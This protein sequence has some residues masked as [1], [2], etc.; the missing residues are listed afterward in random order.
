MVYWTFLTYCEPT[1]TSP[2]HIPFFC[3]SVSN[4]KVH[5]VSFCLDILM[6]MD[7]QKIKHVKYTNEHFKMK[8][9]TERMKP[10]MD[11]FVN[12]ELA[13]KWWQDE[14]VQPKQHMAC[15][16]T[17][18]GLAIVEVKVK[19]PLLLQHLLASNCQAKSSGDGMVDLLREWAS[20]MGANNEGPV[21]SW[22]SDSWNL[23]GKEAREVLIILGGHNLSNPYDFCMAFSDLATM[24]WCSNRWVIGLSIEGELG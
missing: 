5:T 1:S 7:S 22:T 16:N 15:C 20:P 24:G 3:V 2:A 21:R 13:N 23:T 17:I 12:P 18:K 14:T 8:E 11:H 9:T 19:C 10:M 6:S 4:F